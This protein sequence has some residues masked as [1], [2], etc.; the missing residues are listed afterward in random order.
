M[1]RRPQRIIVRRVDNLGDIVLALPV[2]EALRKNYPKAHFTLMVKESHQALCA[3]LA[4]EF[5][6]P[7]PVERFHEFARKYDIAFNIDYFGNDLKEQKKSSVVRH[8]NGIKWEPQRHIATHLAYGLAMHGLEFPS[9]PVPRLPITKDRRTTAK[10]WLEKNGVPAKRSL[11]IG[12]H[13]GSREATK[14]WPTSKYAKLC[15]W[16]HQAFNAHIFF[17]GSET[18]ASSIDI[19]FQA[20]PDDVATRVIA[21]PLDVVAAMLQRMDIL[22]GN[23]SGISHLGAAVKTPTVSLFGPTNP[24]LWRPAGNK[25]VLVLRPQ[26]KGPMHRSTKLPVQTIEQVKQGVH[27]CLQKY[28]KREKFP[29]LDTI[30]VSADI[31]FERTRKGVIVRSGPKG[32]ACLVQDG[33]QRVKRILATVDERKS[34][35]RTLRRFR[36]AGPLLDL[37]I[38]HGIVKWGRS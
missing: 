7:L 38:L 37:F 33:W 9:S 25:S 10:A 27:L 17:F 4:D 32:S 6:P 2:F 18:E 34:Y 20:L 13:I 5:A 24:T 14:R 16:L 3:H 30:S 23:D 22:I 31:Q 28:V 12:V 15:T 11:W 8:I 19:V 29:V 21:Q 36:D 26:P 35:K 1:S